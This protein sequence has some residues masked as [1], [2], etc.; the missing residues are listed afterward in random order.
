MLATQDFRGTV[1]GNSENV[2]DFVRQ[3]EGLFQFAYGWDVLST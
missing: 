2:A 1:Q 3:L